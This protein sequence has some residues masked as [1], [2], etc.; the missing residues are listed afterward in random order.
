MHT[1]VQHRDDVIN[2]IEVAA[3]D[4]VPGQ[5]LVCQGLDS[6]S[7]RHVL[8]LGEYASSICCDYINTFCALTSPHHTT[9]KRITLK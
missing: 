4:I 2:R 3:A 8:R 7:V 1:D 6:T 9:E 5:L